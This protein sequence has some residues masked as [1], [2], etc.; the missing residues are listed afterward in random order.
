[1]SGTDGQIQ[2]IL[3]RIASLSL[4][5]RFS[6]CDYSY[7]QFLN[8]KKWFGEKRFTTREQLI[9]EIEAY[10][11]RLDKLYYSDGLKKLENGLSISS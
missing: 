3:L 8:L 5:A 9:A 11:E 10:F 4:F 1:M 2:Q 7:F 6:S